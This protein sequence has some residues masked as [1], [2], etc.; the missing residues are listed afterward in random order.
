MSWGLRTLIYG[1]VYP[2]WED[3]TDQA[4]GLRI[5]GEI[6]GGVH[7]I[8]F[9]IGDD[10]IDAY[11][12]VNDHMGAKVYIFDNSCNPPVCEGKIMEPSI[13]EE[14]TR[15]VAFGPWMAYMFNQV[16]N[17]AA[18]W[19]GAGQTGA[20]IEDMLTTECPDI[21]TDLSNVGEPA[22]DNWPWQPTNNA[23]PGDLIEGLASLSD[24]TNREWYFF[25]RSG[26]LAGTTPTDPIPYFQYA[27]E[28]PHLYTCQRKDMTPGGLNLTSSMRSLVNDCRV[29]YRSRSGA[30]RQT[31]SGTDA[32]SIARYERREKW[33]FDL[34]HA[35]R[36]AA[37]QYR[38]RLL[39]RYKDPQQ[40]AQFK[41]N[42]WLY[43]EWG[44]KWP[45]WRGIADFPFKITVTD[46]IPDS[47]VLAH[48]LDY[49]RTFI[50]LAAEYDYDSNTLTIIPDTEDNRADAIL[51]RHRSFS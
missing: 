19:V 15:V 24:A 21:S 34:G 29:M 36:V 14:G 38:N 6:H 51:S 22:T 2:T 17:D 45:L 37:R 12:W 20:Q 33:N 4:A 8:E 10:Y 39:A 28:I 9:E 40:S 41:L 13:S 32:T 1:G 50:T 30:Q 16:Y 3:M 48:T 23:Y 47:T 35:R 42:T 18:S 11:R 46:L 31:A 27:A 49:K 26:G 5:L 44:G 25:L 7:A 43:D